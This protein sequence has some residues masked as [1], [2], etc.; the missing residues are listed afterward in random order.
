M[1]SAKVCPQASAKYLPNIFNPDLSL[2]LSSVSNVHCVTAVVLQNCD[3]DQTDRRTDR[4]PYAFLFDEAA[5][6]FV[7]KYITIKCKPVV[8]KQECD[9]NQTDGQ[10]DRHLFVSNCLYTLYTAYTFLRCY[11]MD[12]Y[13]ICEFNGTVNV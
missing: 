4:Q 6:V 1:F 10:T 8:I 5:I 12:I 7:L 13:V 9:L 11:G 2:F 3:L